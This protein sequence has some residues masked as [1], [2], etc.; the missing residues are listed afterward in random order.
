M[1]IFLSGVSQLQMKS[2]RADTWFKGIKM[3]SGFLTEHNEANCLRSGLTWHSREIT[4]A[5][6][7]L[8]GRKSQFSV[9][10]S[11]GGTEDLTVIG[12]GLVVFVVNERR[13][14]HKTY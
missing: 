13:R 8:N 1:M 11:T 10:P 12:L 4:R 14:K 6:A 2:E 9:V 5:R 3:R 7:S